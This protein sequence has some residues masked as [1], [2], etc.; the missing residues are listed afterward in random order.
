MKKQLSLEDVITLLARRCGESGS[1]RAFAEANN[2]S[3]QYITDVLRRKREPGRLVLD[4]LGLKKVVTYA[5][6]EK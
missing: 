6:V 2:I 3:P 5:E 1:Q 4:S